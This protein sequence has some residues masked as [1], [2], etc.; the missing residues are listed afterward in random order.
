MTRLTEHFNF[1]GSLY[2]YRSA[3]AAIPQVAGDLVSQ[4][5]DLHMAVVDLLKPRVAQVL[6]MV[7][8]VHRAG[9]A[10]VAALAAT[11]PAKHKVVP[12]ELR[13]Q[14]LLL[15]G[16]VVSL[17]VLKQTKASV[18]NEMSAFRK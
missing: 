15:C 10:I 11:A 7:R 18:I 4:K 14:L 8:F 2:T 5:E 12:S 3:A 6:H 16:A 13:H 1:A 9:D 17:E